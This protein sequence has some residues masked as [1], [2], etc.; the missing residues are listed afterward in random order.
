MISFY[1]IIFNNWS[2][3]SI[4][5]RSIQLENNQLIPGHRPETPLNLCPLIRSCKH[6][7]FYNLDG[8]E[9]KILF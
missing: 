5:N 3:N 8:F 6:I 2:V 7:F 1:W 4:L 9:I